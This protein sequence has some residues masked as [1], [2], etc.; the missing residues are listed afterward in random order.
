VQP[1]PRSESNEH[2]VIAW[3]AIAAILL[4][5]AAILSAHAEVNGIS[6]MPFSGAAAPLHASL[7]SFATGF[8]N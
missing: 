4:A 2:P 1:R 5:S 8:S 6:E 7:Q 3:L